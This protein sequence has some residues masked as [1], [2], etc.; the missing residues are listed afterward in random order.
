MTKRDVHHL[1]HVDQ[2]REGVRFRLVVMGGLSKL[3]SV[4]RKE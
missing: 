2:K 3:E 1:K 4:E